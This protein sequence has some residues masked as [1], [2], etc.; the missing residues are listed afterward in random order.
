MR[1]LDLAYIL[2]LGAGL[3]L[4]SAHWAVS[5]RPAIGKV[6]VGSWAA[7]PGSGNR[8]IDPYMR[9]F[10][11]R[12][13]HLPLGAG[14]GLELIAQRSDGGEPLDARCR[15]RISGATPPT[16]GWTLGATDASGASF[17]PVLA[18]AGF[19]D[20]ELV[21]GEDGAIS[22]VAAASPQAGNWLPLP[23]HGRFQL[24]LRLYDTPISSQ[25]GET[26]AANLPR[27]T[28]VDCR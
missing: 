8:D 20:A 4:A 14:E 18:R 22:I 5:A 25:T 16:R 21:R 28:R 3:G 10:L 27:I 11:S 24:R 26:Q 19:S 1:I 6:E 15:Y 2:G 7:W 12:G 23:L 13:V 17:S 9:A